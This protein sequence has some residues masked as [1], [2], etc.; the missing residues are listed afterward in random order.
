MTP[1]GRLLGL[2][3]PVLMATTVLT[4]LAQQREQVRPLAFSRSLTCAQPPQFRVGYQRE[5]NGILPLEGGFSFQGV[6]WLEADLCTPG[7]LTLSADGEVAAGEAPRLQI[8]LNSRVLANESFGSR[9]TVQLRVP[10]AGRLTLA[11]FNDY[12]RSD[13]RVATL[14]NFR[15]T[16]RGC[17]TVEAVNVPPETGGA[18]AA[19][20]Q[21]A[22]LVFGVPM[23]LVPC[24]PGELAV[25]VLG[26]AGN[27]VFPRL[28][29]EQ[30]GRTLLELETRETRQ[31]VRLKVTSGPVTITL[32]NPYFKQLA[33][34]NLN[35]R[36]LD[37][38]PDPPSPP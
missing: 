26:R 23:T 16:G 18:W 36:R 17:R 21:T 20:T 3:A 31:A 5:G 24:A 2:V 30:G 33:D 22:T 10:E 6:S 11:Y 27:D 12:Y 37:F 25:R 29:F 38:R 4:A 7:T 35:V 1:W 9:R 15:M 19:S 14:E 32:T 13:A 28:S 8:A 34:R